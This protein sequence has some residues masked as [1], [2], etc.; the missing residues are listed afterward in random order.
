MT[1]VETGALL[2]PLLFVNCGSNEGGSSPRGAVS[3]ETI[4]PRRAPSPVPAATR[5]PTAICATTEVSCAGLCADL[6]R[7][8][9]NCGRCGLS[10][11]RSQQCRL[12]QCGAASVDDR[13]VPDQTLPFQLTRCTGAGESDCGSG[14]VDRRTDSANCGR[15]GNVCPLGTTC[16]MGRCS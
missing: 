6:R 8:S 13:M 16:E 11:G 5:R 14:C 2:L 1:K 15:C 12:G 7:D 4:L 3:A 10:C 9:H